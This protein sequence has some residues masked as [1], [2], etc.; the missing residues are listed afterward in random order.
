MRPTSRGFSSRTKRLLAEESMRVDYSNV[1]S[2]PPTP[3][4]V[5][6]TLLGEVVICSSLHTL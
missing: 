3:E 5:V 4:G 2:T 6:I 1:R